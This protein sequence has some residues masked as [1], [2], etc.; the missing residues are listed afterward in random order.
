MQAAAKKMALWKRIAHAAIRPAFVSAMLFLV[1]SPTLLRAQGASTGVDPRQP[2]KYFDTIGSERLGGARPPLPKPVG[3][4]APTGVDTKPLFVLHGVSISGARA[5]APNAMVASYQAYLGRKV[6]QADLAAIAE[7]VTQLYRTAGYHLTRAIVPPQD[8]K[9]GRINI[10]VIEGSIIEVVLKGDGVDKFGIRP[11][12]ET[13]MSEQ[14]SRQARLERALLLVNDRPGVRVADTALEE[15]GTATGRFRLIVFLKTWQVYT[16]FGI[17]NLGSASVGPWQ[18][19]ATGAFNS[20]LTPGDSLVLNLSTIPTDPRQLG[21]GRL[22]Y[23]VPV[24]TDGMKIG[25]SALYSEVRP[26]DWRSQYND[27]TKTESFEL[28][29]SIVPLQSQN[30]TLTLTAAAM[31]S[32]VSDGDAFGTLYSDH[33]RTISL[34]ANYRLK[35]NFDGVNYLTA[36]WRQ[37]LDVFGASRQGDDLLSRNG[38]SGSFSS[39]NLWFARYQALCDAWSLKIAAAGQYASTPLLTSQQYYVGGAAFG[40]GYGSAEISGDDGIAGSLELRFDQNVDFHTLK[41]YQLYG[42]VESGAAWNV[43]YNYTDGLS[44]TSAGGGIRLFF[45]GDLRA[46][47]GVAFPLSYRAPDNDTRSARLLFSLSSAFRLCPEK[48]RFGCS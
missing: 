18:S 3:S 4:A 48:V 15:I 47:L 19:Y 36:T 35:D 17:D 20:Y 31:L 44:L 33:L 16:E 5:I 6:S 8:I 27:I 25:G 13:V 12:I 28:R 26:G 42:F 11:M 37:G 10:T 14:P 7:A 39:V 29:A 30:M 41:S 1:A 45:D 40:R 2:E 43:G 34:T 23:D 22:S 32:N 24:G 21:F 38:G 9:Q 46:D